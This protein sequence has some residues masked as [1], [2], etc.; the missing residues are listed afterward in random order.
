MRIAPLLALA[1]VASLLVGCSDEPPPEI[2]RP[3]EAVSTP[4]VYDETLEPAASVMAI[5]PADATLLEV[6]DYDEVRL[7]LGYGD[8]SSASP[9]EVLRRFWAEAKRVAPLLSTGTFRSGSENLPQPGFTQDDVSWEARFSGPSGEGYVVKFRDDLAMAGVQ[10]AARTPGNPI[11]G[12]TVVPGARIAAVGATR[13]PEESWAAE[14]DLLALVGPKAGSTYVSRDCVS[15]TDAFGGGRGPAAGL[16]ALDELGPF[17]VAFGGRLVTARL[18]AGRADV[19]DRARRAETT[20]TTAPEF[21]RAFSDPVVGD[22]AG[23]RI[24]FSLGDGR[25]AAR[26]TQARQL[27]FAV[28]G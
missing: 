28:C 25:A 13:E 4:P 3:P 21:V 1:S 20:A 23:G 16:D 12:A 7:S 10:R 14:P 8:L 26:L 15:E 18:G 17:S 2:V 5:V 6:T 27:P 9:P 24:G 22:P 11:Q 19:F